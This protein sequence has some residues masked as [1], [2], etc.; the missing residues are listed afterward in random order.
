[1]RVITEKLEQMDA[2]KEFQGKNLDECIRRAM[3]W[4]D[5]P[6]DALEVEI[7]QDAKSGIFGIVGARKAIIR[8]RRA[9][10]QETLRNILE[11]ADQ[12]SDVSIQQE[13]DA[14]AIAHPPGKKQHGESA[15]ISHARDAQ[16]PR[17][18]PEEESEGLDEEEE[19]EFVSRPIDALDKEKLERVA[20]EVVGNLVSS[21]AGHDIGVHFDAGR[22]RPR[23]RIDWKG[24]A[25]L[26]IGREGQTLIALQYLASR[27]ISRI[28]GFSLH[29]QLDVG[30]YRERQEDRLREMAQALAE[31][32]RRTGRP[33]STKPLSSYQR[34]VIH[35]SLQQ[36]EDIQTRSMGD[37]LLKRVLISPRRG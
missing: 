25:G 6:R 5:C 9:R 20:L 1:M 19:G 4:F 23:V 17:L 34:R 18:Q 21:I 30:E 28:M 37:G 7:V 16:R 14:E 15:D 31:R 12:E 2:Y 29:L 22:A 3:Q 33:C 13:S 36:E 26:L 24:D 10:V 27:I 11:N 32:A 35:L 8:A